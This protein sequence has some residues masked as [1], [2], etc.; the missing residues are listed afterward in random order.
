MNSWNGELQFYGMGSYVP[1]PRLAV[2]VV[3]V[4]P[5][6]TK[7]Q[8]WRRHLTENPQDHCAEVK[9]F[10]FEYHNFA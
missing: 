1:V 10:H 6:E 5:H 2:V 4:K 9:I 8:A 7:E 3:L